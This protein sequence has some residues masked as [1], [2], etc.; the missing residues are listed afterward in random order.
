MLEMMAIQAGAGDGVPQ[1]GEAGVEF[2][3]GYF[4]RRMKDEQNNWYALVISPRAEGSGG[5]S[6]GAWQSAMQYVAGLT[7]GGYNDW[8]LMSR[9]EARIAYREFKPTT[10]VN[11]TNYGATSRVEPPLGNYTSSNPGQT[12]LVDWR[13]GGSEA[14]LTST[15]YWMENESS[16]YDAYGMTFINGTEGSSPKGSSHYV[17]AVRR[18]YF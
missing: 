17:R 9:D 11:N 2:G 3:G 18:H 4:C 8:K 7:I 12:P 10:S 6:T 1:D 13:A 14:F 16:L 15:Y 5:G